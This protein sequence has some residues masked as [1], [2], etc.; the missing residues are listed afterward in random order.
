MKTLKLKKFMSLCL[1]ALICVTTLAG[2]GTTAYA[3]EIIDEAYLVSF[4]RDGDANYGGEWGHDNLSF[5]QWVR[6]RAISVTA[7]N[8]AFRWQRATVSPKK[9]RIFGIITPRPTT[10]P[11]PPMILNCSSEESFSTATRVWF[12]PLGVHRMRATTS[13]LTPSLRSF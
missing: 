2:F 6:T 8:P 3:A 9:A 13:W 11:F 7:L 4:P 12:R 10:A 1:A 5:M